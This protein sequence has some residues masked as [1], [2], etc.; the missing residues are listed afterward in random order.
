[1]SRAAG[2]PFDEA[3]Q[4]EKIKKTHINPMHP[5]LLRIARNWSVARRPSVPVVESRPRRRGVAEAVQSR[6]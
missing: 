2:I 4:S 5:E 6:G 1:M 3:R